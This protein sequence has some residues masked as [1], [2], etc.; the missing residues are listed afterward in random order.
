MKSLSAQNRKIKPSGSII[1]PQREYLIETLMKAQYSRAIKLAY[2]ILRNSDEASDVASDVLL[3][4]LLMEK[5][6]FSAIHR[7]DNYYHSAVYNEALRIRR[8]RIKKNLFPIWENQDLGGESEDELIMNYFRR[9]DKMD[10]LEDLLEQLE[11]PRYVE[12][13]RLFYFENLSHRE[14]AKVMNITE[15]NSKAILNR[16]KNALKSLFDSIPPEDNPN[17]GGKNQNPSPVKERY[18]GRRLDLRKKEDNEIIDGISPAT[19]VEYDQIDIGVFLETQIEKGFNLMIKDFGSQ[20]KVSN[21][22]AKKEKEIYNRIIVMTRSAGKRRHKI[23]KRGHL[24]PFNDHSNPGSS[25]STPAKTTKHAPLIDL[26][27]L[28]TIVRELFSGYCGAREFLQAGYKD[29]KTLFNK[30][31][32]NWQP[33]SIANSFRSEFDNL[34][35]PI[36]AMYASG[37]EGNYN[38]WNKNESSCMMSLNQIE[39]FAPLTYR[40]EGPGLF[41]YLDDSKFNVEVPVIDYYPVF[42]TKGTENR[43]TDPSWSQIENEG[44]VDNTE[45]TPEIIDFRRLDEIVQVSSTFQ[46]QAFLLRLLIR[47]KSNTNDNNKVFKLMAINNNSFLAHATSVTSHLSLDDR[48]DGFYVCLCPTESESSDSINGRIQMLILFFSYDNFRPKSN[49]TFLAGKIKNTC[50]IGKSFSESSDEH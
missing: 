6:R 44:N 30:I 36:T 23:E 1:S 32:Y 28:P 46:A 33:F 20:E 49:F 29:F 26:I 21:F 42:L 27:F 35:L 24:Y 11:N 48:R 37:K 45:W 16:A 5:E 12:I 50:F 15:N 47:L 34:K 14:I 18:G 10:I 25:K 43:T 19:T 8:L 38:I 41:F 13:I 7:L 9:P 4:L 17:G 31:H 39:K 2:S 22:I 3:N 40:N